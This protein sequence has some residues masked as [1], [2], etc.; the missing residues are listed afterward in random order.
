M[1]AKERVTFH[2][3]NGPNVVAQVIDGEALLIDF[4]SGTYY[5]ARGSG[6]AI[7]DG[8]RRGV[9]DQRILARLS[10]SGA[11]PAAIAQDLASFLELLCASQL[12]VPQDVDSKFERSEENW[13][14]L[15]LGDYAA[16][17]LEKF[18]DL[19]D[20]LLLDPIHDV[21]AAGWPV[22]KAPA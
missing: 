19:Q 1:R 3:I 12:I 4:E 17:V 16:P 6:G 21:D 11:E 20:L 15:A 2:Q 7:L 9:S 5:S 18:T 14:P 10:E 22:A 13:E 8:I